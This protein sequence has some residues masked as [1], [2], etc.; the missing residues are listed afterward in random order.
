MF[1]SPK[2]P[3]QARISA[4]QLL[5][6]ILGVASGP[7]FGLQESASASTST[8]SETE[9]QE[10]DTFFLG[11]TIVTATR[12]KSKALGAAYA[13][14]AISTETI[15]E[16]AYRT[17][18]QI[19]RDTPGVMVQETSHGQGSPYIRGFTG[20]RNLLL[21]D[22]IRLNNSVFRSGPNQYW[23][24]VDPL[25]VERLEVVKGPGSVLYGSD[26]IGGTVNVITKN[27][28][29][30]GP[31][32]GRAG[33]LYQRYASAE[34]S[35]TSRLELGASSE[36]QLGVLMGVGYKDFGD[37]EGGRDTGVQPNTG[38]D[39]WNADLKLE[40][41]LDADQRLVFA[42]QNVRQNDVPRTHRTVDAVPF[43]GTSVGSDLR[44]DL[45]QERQLGYL[46]LQAENQ[47]AFYDSYQVSLSW[48][49]QAEERNRIRGN[50]NPDR[51]GFEVDTLGFF[52]HLSSPSPVGKWTY[53]LDYY[54]DRVDSF[55]DG[56]PIQGPVG[57][58]ATYDL[59]G[60]FVQDEF[61]L[62]QR[63]RVTLGGRFNYAGA[64]AN[65][66]LDPVSNTQTSVD[67]NWSS[68][69]SSA[70][71]VY[72]LVDDRVNLFGGISQGFRAPNLSD[73]TRFDTARTN[74][75]EIPAPGLDPEEFLS[76]EL[77]VKGQLEE[78]SS[79]V[80][81]F[82]TDIK[83]Q[84]SLFPTG[85]TNTAGEAEIT[86]A[87]VGD[88]YVYG[89]EAGAALE[90]GS[91]WTLFGN[92]TYIEGKAETFPTSAPVKSKEYIDRLMPLS[93]QLG[94][95]WDEPEGE[96]WAELLAVFAD[97][98]DRISP[99]DAADSSRIPPG[100]TP[101]YLTFSLRG[102]WQISEALSLN[103]GLENLLD[104]DYRIHGS[105]QNS[106]GRSLVLGL[107]YSL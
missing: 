30:Y 12:S 14:E 2:L 35:S 33:S 32:V 60:I 39:E 15:R 65:S 70:R 53:G 107:S 67:E 78:L 85:N 57:D 52:M 37:L 71:F 88:G 3:M 84:I 95:R 73:L 55:R 47:D 28:D 104:E 45:D 93:A 64:D 26:A 66:V 50:G 86:K 106:P 63:L 27:P 8:T 20:Y 7:A 81:L 17:V 51:Q 13:T 42:Y 6:L 82:Y 75:F 21:I 91:D 99:R 83:D 89:I 61:E 41:F 16:R 100:G 76:F 19:L 92:A 80:S 103:V 9:K 38:Y 87:N 46:Q 77:G 43:E 48:Q 24:T 31:G 74:E 18:P 72:G 34:H 10:P 98:A 22:G 11:E 68:W 44:R 58:D 5:I 94:T 79:Q 29:T 102:G 90:L 4:P 36:E 59:F 56:Q 97:D 1:P 69:V 40:R 25:S 23:N 49:R 96:R 101:G 105:G 62:S 54:H